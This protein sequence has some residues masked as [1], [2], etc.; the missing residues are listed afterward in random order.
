M[1]PLRAALGGLLVA[2]LLLSGCGGSSSGSGSGGGKDNG[3]AALDAKDI[4]AKSQAA[5]KAADSVHVTGNVASE[6]Q[7]V[8]IDMRLKKGVGGRGTVSV[9]SSPVEILRIGDA[10]YLKAS[11]DFWTQVANAAVGAK[12]ADKYVKGSTKDATFKSFLSFTDLGSMFDSIFDTS[13]TGLQKVDGKT[14]DGVPTVGIK[15]PDPQ[16]GGTLY[17]AT[18]GQPYP[19]LIES[20][21]AS[22]DKGSVTFDEWNKSIELTSPPADQVLDISN[23]G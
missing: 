22:T 21:S 7:T 4:V 9:G 12:L 13:S 18:Q 23:L 1:R 16:N 11:K 3:I 10:A 5:A 15:D 20:D 8:T 2:C 6:G 17:V 19:L 14:I